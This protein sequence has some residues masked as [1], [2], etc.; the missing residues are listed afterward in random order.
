M[1][2]RSA[3]SEIAAAYAPSSG[4]VLLAT[5]AALALVLACGLVLNR[6]RPGPLSRSLAWLLV[7]SS[8]LGAH[9]ALLD[10]A[11]GFRMLALIALTLYALKAV[12]TVESRA[13]GM[14]PLG[15]L[16][17]LAFAA[18]WFGMRPRVF[19]ERSTGPLPGAW[20]LLR[21][22]LVCPLLGGLLIAAARLT[23]SASGS[24]V[25]A[26]LP[27]LV[28]LSLCLHFGLFNLTAAVWRTAG[29]DARPLFRAPLRSTSLREFWGKRWNL[30]FSEMTSLA[31]FRPLRPRLGP[32]VAVTLAFLF[33]GLLHEVAI[34][35]PVRAGYGLPFSYFA[36]QALAM[37]GER[38][39]VE[40]GRLAGARGRLWTIAWLVL[41]APILFH[42]P[43]LSGVIWPLIG[44]A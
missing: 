44:M 3:S 20:S 8:G 10:E 33:S 9:L 22:G 35:L 2:A 4:A 24:R 19:A 7:L 26:T 42:R 6:L 28:G 29:V 30:A 18:A 34:S 15:P 39:M 32:S 11:A 12:V 38:R 23:W 5:C 27:L 21:N 25:A 31:V 13:A 37:S 14:T 41:P 40:R 16:A 17:W 43:F 36:L 1:S